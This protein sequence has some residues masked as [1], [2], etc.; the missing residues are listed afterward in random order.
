[1]KKKRI[2]SIILTLS[3]ALTIMPQQIIGGDYSESVYADETVNTD[4]ICTV[5][6][7]ST[8]TISWDDYA[9]SIKEINLSNLTGDT[10][11]LYATREYIK[12]NITSNDLSSIVGKYNTDITKCFR[13]TSK[14]CITN[15]ILEYLNVENDVE[16]Y[17]QEYN[18][19]DSVQRYP[20]M[21]EYRYWIK[22]WLSVTGGHRPCYCFFNSE[23]D[24]FNVTY[25][26]NYQGYDMLYING[27]MNN[28]LVYYI[29]NGDMF[30]SYTKNTDYYSNSVEY[31]NIDGFHLRPDLPLSVVPFIFNMYETNMPLVFT[32]TKSQQIVDSVG[33][34]QSEDHSFHGQVDITKFSVDELLGLINYLLSESGITF[35]E[36]Y[37]IYKDDVFI[38][39]S[40]GTSFI[41][42][43]TFSSGEH[44]YQVYACDAS[45]KVIDKSNSIT[46]NTQYIDDWNITSD[47]KL[48]SD[49][50][51]SNLNI[52]RGT[53]DLN[54][55]TLTVKG[56]VYLGTSSVITYLNIN[57]GKLYVDGNFN[58][59]TSN[60]TGNYGVLQ[61]LNVDDYVLVKGNFLAR[62]Y[63][64]SEGN[65]TAGTLEV[66]G[67]FAQWRYGN[68][69]NYDN[70]CATGTH[71]VILSGDKLQTLY[72][73]NIESQFNIL[74]IQNYS[75][76]GVK[77]ST[78]L[79]I[80][81]LIDNG[82]IIRFPNGERVGWTLEKDETFEGDLYLGLGTL[83]LNGYKL[84]IKGNLIH[85][86]G[87]VDVNGGELIVQGNYRMQ[88]LKNVEYGT[89][90]ASLK[91]TNEADIVRVLG[92]FITKTT[93]SHLGL[94]TAGTLE[95]GGDL[96]QVSG[97]STT[98]FRPSETH[99]VILNGNKKQTV[100]IANSNTDYSRI[101]NLKI[102]NTSSSGVNFATA[103]YVSGKLYNTET[104]LSGYWIVLALT[105]SLESNSWNY[106]LWFNE[107]RTLSADTQISGT[108]YLDNCTLDLNG[109]ELTVGGNVYLSAVNYPTY[110]NINKGKLYIGESF[111]ITTLNNG[112]SSGRLI[113]TNTDDYVLINGNFN[114][115]TSV[116]SNGY[117]TAGTLEIKGN[118]TQRAGHAESFYA[119]G[120]HKVILSGDA[121]QAVSFGSTSSKFNILEITKPID[122]GYKFNRT[123]VW[124][125][126][127][128]V[129]HDKIA[130]TAPQNLSVKVHSEGVIQLTWTA[131]TDNVKV[132]GY[133]IYRNGV[134]IGFSN[135]SSFTDNS[136]FGEYYEYYV[137][138]VD[139]DGNISR[140]SKTVSI[141]NLAPTEPVLTLETVNEK[142]ISL[143]FNSTD[144]VG[145]VKYELYKDGVKYKTL[146][147]NT[148]VDTAVEIDKTYEYYV[149]AYDAYGNA[150]EKSNV[151]N[152]FT[153]NDT[154]APKITSITPAKSVYSGNAVITVK[155][156]D[157]CAVKTIYIQA[158][159]DK[160]TWTD[161]GTINAESRASASVITFV[162]T[163]DFAD[164]TLYIRAYAED[165]TGNKSNP[166]DSPIA[167][168]TVDNTAPSSPII[169]SNDTESG[170]VYIAWSYHDTDN[171]ISYFRVYRKSNK[172]S[173]YKLIK[174]NYTFIDFYDSNIEL[175]M[176]YSYVVTAV[177]HAGN[178]SVLSNEAAICIADD[179][180]NPQILSMSPKTQ[181]KISQNPTMSISCYDNLMLKS[182]IVERKDNGEWIQIYNSSLN[183]YAQVVSFDID[184]TGLSSGNY[185]FRAKVTDH[186]GNESDYFTVTYDYRKCTLSQPELTATGKGWSVELNW[187]MT[188][189][190]E[191][192]GYNVYKKA[193][194]DKD[195]SKF[196]SIKDTVLTDSNVTAGQKY[197]YMVEA[198][199]KYGNFVMGNEIFSI[200]THEDTIA[201]V[202]NAGSDM[203]AVMGKAVL[204]DGSGSKD[205]YYIE[206]Y[207][208]DFG[209]G[210]TAET[211]RATHT[212]ESEGTY[213]A[214]LKVK[215]SSGN[216]NS[217]SVIVK[218]YSNDYTTVKI[219]SMDVNGSS[220]GEVRIYMENEDGEII[221][222]YTNSSGNY[223]LILKKGNYEVYFYK[224]GYLPQ[225]IK[226]DTNATNSLN[227]RLEKKEL[228]SGELKVRELEIN[229]IIALGIDI[230][231]PANQFVYQYEVEVTYN[232]KTGKVTFTSNQDG[233]DLGI[234]NE[235]VN[236]ND[237]TETFV[238]II[239]RKTG[240]T[241]GSGFGSGS[242]S[243]SGGGGEKV[244]TKP[245]IA[246]FNITTEI[247]WLKE[248]YDVEL[249][250]I[251]NA[252]EEFNIEE[253]MAVLHLPD[254]LSLA[255]T[256]RGED[257]VID[258]G[259]IGGNETK[260]VSWVI[261]GDKS[262]SY[263]IS[264]DFTGKLMPF[265]EDVKVTFKNKKPIEILGGKALK[266][267]IV[268]DAWGKTDNYW[269]TTFTLTNISDKPIYNVQFDYT[270]YSE[271]SHVTDM[272]L[273]YPDGTIEII[274]W[275]NGKPSFDK[276]Q[277]FLP[278]FL[279][280]D[281]EQK[282]TLNPGESIIGVYS[283]IKYN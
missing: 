261:R 5:N 181:S 223:D 277:I 189:A 110:L 28:V 249:T 247:S 279:E 149:I 125:Q 114:S 281:I 152:V 274:P 41:D 225:L 55:Y 74:E 56:N 64:S 146:M 17:V 15:L 170:K 91:M 60:G 221:D 173:I 142:Y 273:Y 251:N 38:G 46:V 136:A 33:F 145:V 264:A 68:S 14:S 7:D 210:M 66:K 265:S 86:G 90:I 129:T 85:S 37:H 233:D 12:S 105:G 250:I 263:N 108:L 39:Q 151:L 16:K 236:Y 82:C 77:L 43:D 128:E 166:V 201:P 116:T 234:V 11:V 22:G 160:V 84:T 35:V 104:N 69:G 126:L 83:D 186:A 230:T 3:M 257:N 238:E 89:S 182:L 100:T 49:K 112:L 191:I 227:I 61:M 240:S 180:I 13:Y 211:A 154:I 88:S 190:E 195:Y 155:A 21:S 73:E 232:N 242:G 102:T 194:T 245:I 198:V 193:A 40:D 148:F 1:M 47:T 278:A 115:Y 65:L 118:F 99:T 169:K 207:L 133:N 206:S 262:G 283:I 226:I 140:P 165:I 205:N 75:S 204:F 8:V 224:S 72:F 94:L 244:V 52:A 259:T 79:T 20:N 175:G 31:R 32:D 171:D 109:Y 27:P 96:T 111:N 237:D 153:G 215:D 239:P 2:I 196:A 172:E 200:P 252:D 209:D 103:V 19:N 164:G 36:S 208:W 93:V 178:E 217:Q 42:K 81:K 57:K 177:D 260:S 71:K 179:K 130:P 97:G 150:S 268:H 78:I 141:D 213:T 176:E 30:N 254:G 127:I 76:Y 34:T 197:Y 124:N 282:L 132:E 62:G 199:D 80:N 29:D 53:L 185:D 95:I 9:N 219:K 158:S 45:G 18:L 63:Y 70:F 87:V 119:S 59:S 26:D 92:D 253:A 266:L 10:E 161:T 183:K 44:K 275:N 243:G 24:Y 135:G 54:G 98:S 117:L 272:K 218:V 143:S 51:V 214:T 222:V 138:A 162:D 229:E 163:K 147:T 48:T 139:N 235:L 107:N 255:D 270:G 256:T 167:S 144:N 122:I 101:N 137:E 67:D 220:L 246:V 267:D 23:Q 168:I 50:T 248:F 258:M 280:F 157:N 231:N 6:K 123:P 184:M 25:G 121:I 106:N 271:F 228:V 203:Q 120:T 269:T 58:I 113:M 4:I 212:Y 241:W 134:N 202:A 187:T 188:N 131:S 216:I 192:A 174:D 276:K 156:E 159:S